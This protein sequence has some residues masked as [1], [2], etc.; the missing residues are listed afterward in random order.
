MQWMSLFEKELLENWRNFK[1]IWVPLVLVLLSIMDP[2]ST[3]FM[4]QIIES[5]GGLPEG[6]VFEMPTPTANEAIMMSIAQ[7]SSLGVLVIVLMSMGVIANERK[8]GVLELLLVKPVRHVNYITAKWTALLLLVWIGLFVGMLG[9]WYY[10]NLLFGELSFVAML[11]VVFFYGLWLTLVVTLSIFF[12]TLFK[13]PG[14]VAFMTITT[15]MAMSL[16]TKIFGT[17]LTWSPNNLASH[18]H[19]LLLIHEVT[20]DLA[21]TSLITVVISLVLLIASVYTFKTKE[22]AN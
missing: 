22:M 9:S 13:S 12:N 15:I 5:V 19:E 3:Y 4:P 8:S 7:L 21:I 20:R 6:A 10:V 1:W 14:L 2:I 11:Q 17:Y 18:I 16:I